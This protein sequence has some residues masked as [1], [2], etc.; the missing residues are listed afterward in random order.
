MTPRTRTGSNVAERT[1]EV[2]RLAS[3]VLPSR[4]TPSREAGVGERGVRPRRRPRRPRP[5]KTRAGTPARHRARSRVHRLRW[6]AGAVSALCWALIGLM[7][8]HPAFWVQRI[9][10]IGLVR[11]PQERIQAWEAFQELVGRPVVTVQPESLVRSLKERFPAFREVRVQVRLPGRVVL[12]VVERDPVLVWREG[13]ETF[14]VDLEGVK[15]H[16]EGSS[17]PSWP[18]V[19]VQGDRY[20]VQLRPQDVALILE[21]TRR[22]GVQDLVFH[23][24]Y[25]FGWTTPEGW[26]VY[27]GTTMEDWEARWALY[28]EVVAA[29]RERG[30]VPRVIRLVSSQAVVVLPGEEQAP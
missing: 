2:P 29:L 8:W 7:W 28:E 4:H 14:W 1:P 11:V 26:Q 6:T 22:A 21:L 13:V 5:P 10:V 20:G 27:I 23:P 25:G 30:Q 3:V 9:Q 16:A 19:T 24:Q 17:D 15:F 18:R 12:Q